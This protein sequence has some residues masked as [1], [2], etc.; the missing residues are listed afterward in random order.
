MTVVSGM[1]KQYNSITEPFCDSVKAAFGD[2]T[3]FQTQGGLT[4]MGT[5]MK[6]GMVL[7]MSLWDDHAANMLWLDSTYPTTDSQSTPGAYRGTCATSSGTPASVESQNA[8]S[9]VIYSNIKFGPL[10]STFTP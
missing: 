2:N 5:A 6:S 4:Q 3:D 8:G 9:S 1:S 10:N 7:V